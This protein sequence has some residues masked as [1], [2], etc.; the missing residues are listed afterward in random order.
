MNGIININHEIS[1]YPALHNVFKINVQ[2]SIYKISNK[3]I[4]F[5]FGT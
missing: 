4:K 2:N 5:V 3:N 1:L